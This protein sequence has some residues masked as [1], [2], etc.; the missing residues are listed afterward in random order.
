MGLLVGNTTIIENGGQYV[1]YSR[2]VSINYQSVRA[3]IGFPCPKDMAMSDAMFLAEQIVNAKLG[4]A[5]ER[6]KY[7]DKL[8][9]EALGE[10]IDGFRKRKYGL[11]D[12]ST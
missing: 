3:G 10:S 8:C 5:I 11:K 2:T 4:L 7:V 12:L 6:P 1:E 9:H